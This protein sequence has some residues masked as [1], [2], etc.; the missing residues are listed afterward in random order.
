[1]SLSLWFYVLNSEKVEVDRNFKIEYILPDKTGFTIIPPSEV[2][3]SLKGPKAFLDSFL[4]RRNVLPIDLSLETQNS[5]GVYNISLKEG[6]LD[7]PLGVEVLEFENPNINLKTGPLIRKS[8][9]L[10]LNLIGKVS[11]KSKMISSNISPSSV[12]LEGTKEALKGIKK[13]ETRPLDLSKLNGEGE[14]D[15][16]F[17]DLPKNVNVVDDLVPKFQYKIVPSEI[18]YVVKDVPIRFLSSRTVLESSQ[19]QVSLLVYLE[20]ETRNIDR[21]EVQV[22]AD[23]PE[24]GENNQTVSLKATVPSGVHLL[25][26]TPKEIKVK[27]K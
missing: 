23:I 25:E 7:L 24:G 8:F 26:I 27:L 3:I 11:P 13:L 14:V 16:G 17:L 1:M 10:Q 2:K 5:K 9:P 6:Y 21:D 18:N 12:I 22:V 20:D 4:S 19:K 15:L